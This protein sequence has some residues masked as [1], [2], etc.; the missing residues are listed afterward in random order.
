MAS[1][2]PPLRFLVEIVARGRLIARAIDVDL[3]VAA[4]RLSDLER[5]AR[6]RTRALSGADRGVL[7]LVGAR[8]RRP[9]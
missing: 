5:L 9:R 2:A 8:T 7:L 3:S 4:A 1:S 6:E